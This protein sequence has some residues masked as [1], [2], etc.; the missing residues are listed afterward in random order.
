[1][2]LFVRKGCDFCHGLPKVD[3][4]LTFE[5]SQ[6]S[7]G[8]RMMVDGHLIPVPAEIRGLPALKDGNAII[9]GKRLVKEHLERKTNTPGV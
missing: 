3:G 1:M 8:P 6:T 5:V 9:M 2:L 4:L 7:Q